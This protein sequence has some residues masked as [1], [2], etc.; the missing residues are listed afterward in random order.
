MSGKK[1]AAPRRAT[2]EAVG[3]LKEK[4]FAAVDK[5]PERWAG[6][7]NRDEILD[8]CLRMGI[9]RVLTLEA[10]HDKLRREGKRA[11]GKLRRTSAGRKSSKS[12]GAA[13][14]SAAS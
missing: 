8:Y 13:E 5:N 12:N 1:G 2:I 3:E 10:Q 14:A 11:S 9:N 4:L 6:Y 7:K